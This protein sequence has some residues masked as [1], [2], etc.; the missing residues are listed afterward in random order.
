MIRS[1]N[2]GADGEDMNLKCKGQSHTA[3]GD[4]SLKGRH[5]LV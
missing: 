2:D 1:V 4:V 3:L 5:E